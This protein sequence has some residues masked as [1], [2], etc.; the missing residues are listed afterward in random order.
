ML[1]VCVTL[2]ASQRFFNLTYDQ[3]KIDSALPHVTYSLPLGLDYQDSIY[4]VSILYPDFIELPQADVDQYNKISGAPLS[5]LPVINQFIAVNSKQPCLVVSFCPIVFRDGHYR[6]LASY[7][8]K[9][10]SSAINKTRAK[11]SATISRSTVLSSRYAISSV[12]SSGSWAK[13]KIASSGVFELTDAL[14]RKAGFSD[15]SKVHIYGYG[16]NLQNEVLNEDELIAYDDLKEVALCNINGKRLFYGRGPVS[17][18]S[19]DAS[20][21]TRN[22]YSDYGYYFITQNDIE[23][24][25]VDSATFIN[26]FYPSADDYHSLYEVDGYS[27]YHGGR[28]LFDKDE[29][30]TGNSK[31]IILNN[32]ANAKSGKLSVNVSAGSNS[33]VQV[34][35]ND[36]ILGTLNISLG[37]YDN[38][39][40]AGNTYYINN[41][42]NEENI[43]IKALSG[44]PIRLD[45]VSMAWDTPIAAPDITKGS[46]PIPEYVSNISNQNHH[47]DKQADMVIIIPTSGKL[48]EQAER[49]KKFHETHDSLSVNIVKADEL[50][51][52][53]S[54]GTPDANAY[55]KYLKM[56][57]DRA[58]TTAGAPKYLLLFGDGVWDNRMLTADTKTYDKDDYLLCY[59][60]ENSFNSITCYVDDGFYALLDD[61]EGGDPQRKDTPDISVGRFP[62]TSAAEAKIMVDKTI[63]YV[64]NE[65]AGAWQNTMMFMGDDGNQNLHMDDANNAADMMAE[66][67]PN[68]LI[69]KV[70]WDAYKRETS[71]T[72]NTYPDV[73]KIIKQQQATGALIMDYAGHG[74]EIKISHES[75]L[76][77]NDFATF[78]NKALPLWITAS[79]DIMPFDG[80]TAT[81]GEA[82]VLNENGGAVAFFGT[83]RT[84]Y[85]QYNKVLNMAYLN[86][87]LD[88]TGG[89]ANT[90][91]DAQRLAKTEMITTGKDLTTNKLQYSLLGDPAIS[92]I[93]PSQNIV[94]DSINGVSTLSSTLPIFKGG[95]IARI[96]GHVENATSLTGIIT[97]T[98]RDSR[99]L[100][101]CRLN[102]PTEADSAFQYYDR[103]KVLYNGS[104]SVRAGK[105]A[106][107]FA[108]PKDI[109]YSDGTGLIN[110]YA[111][112][113]DRSITANGHSDHF[114][115][116]GSDVAAND[117]IG[118]AIY[119]YLNSPSFE[120]GGNVNTTPYFVAQIKDENGINVTGSGI[121]H[122]LELIIDGKATMT[123]NLNDNFSYDFGTYKSG[124]T[125][126]NIPELTEGRHK[127]QFRSWDILNN[128]STAQLDFNVVNKL[129]PNLFGV[130]LS[131][132]PATTTTTFIVNHDRTGS[133]MDVQIEV[134]DMSG[135]ILWKHSETAI[136]TSSVY[137]VTWDLCTDGG[138]RLHTGVY[139]YRVKIS[140]E[141]SSKVSKSHKLIVIDNN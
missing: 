110:L 38:G 47:A 2:S 60:S 127:L 58:S 101:T 27:W 112:N 100:I 90:I 85:A 61:G 135:R 59:E 79:C 136:P 78:N 122:N 76:G 88:Y 32:T 39:N 105:F 25:T 107:S 102:D 3:V 34:M 24:Q 66:K 131:N 55:R 75:V 123:Y 77:L 115:V 108:V 89:K 33:M 36:S 9:V 37:S 23:P 128:S 91:G 121:G 137:T 28:N 20:R 10:E 98:V 51:N 67:Y 52:E 6:I 50:Y 117:S 35:L 92:L 118:P 106:F 129:E 71:T 80:T 63:N 65:N 30:T 93:K 133:D 139:L 82:A 49:L 40:E 31:N 44:G 138:N 15:I 19:N 68:Y 132:N 124:T 109:N 113:S 18:S 64:T 94:I 86:Y 141:G 26:S 116:G 4:K 17:W 48:L 125:Y 45:Y 41:L 111:V 57:Y 120:N 12:L 7:M 84:V 69:K 95:S 97:A 22:P 140:S 134:F 103:T 83:T 54:S 126:Y 16:G 29:I 56:L 5:E 99:E 130:S 53:F 104:D 70:I 87:V 43:S 119:C 21:R 11:S 114:K 72:G 1:A 46:F 8:L 81:I 74:S 13:I 42:K 73:T 14:I 96:S 62:V